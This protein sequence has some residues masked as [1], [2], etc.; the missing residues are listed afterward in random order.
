MRASAVIA[1]LLLVLPACGALES[2]RADPSPR[3]S[4]ELQ[5]REWH[6]RVVRLEGEATLAAE[7]GDDC[8]ASCSIA[9]RACELTQQICDLARSDDSDEGTRVLCEDAEP[10][11]SGARSAAASHCTCE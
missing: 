8:S 11:C 1:F 7:R 4:D 9:A 2:E 6:D 10:R 3:E 5:A